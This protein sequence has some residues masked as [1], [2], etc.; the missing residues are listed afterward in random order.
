MFHRKRDFSTLVADGKSIL[1][2]CQIFFAHALDSKKQKLD[3]KSCCQERKIQNNL[4][5]RHIFVDQI[6]VVS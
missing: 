5:Q 4:K 1:Y 6:N 3:Q 2:T